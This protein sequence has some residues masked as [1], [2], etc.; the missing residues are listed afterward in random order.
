MI[1]PMSFSACRKLLAVLAMLF[2][3]P[4][5]ASAAEPDFGFTLDI[6]MSDKA[7]QKLMALKE[8]VSV[9]AFWEGEPTKAAP[10]KEYAN[11]PLT[12]GDEK[13]ILPATGGQAKFLG[14][15]VRKDR[16]NWVQGGV[17]TLTIGVNSAYLNTPDNL[18]NC[19]IVDGKLTDFQ[20]KTVTI[21]CKLLS[22]E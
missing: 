19:D 4:E 7:S 22:G 11:G 8:K 14:T 9:R 17:L 10:K 18:L 16:M 3:V 20:S 13:L 1:S 5:P 15:S 2:A 12:L 21:N 6:R